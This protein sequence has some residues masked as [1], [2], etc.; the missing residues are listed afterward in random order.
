MAKSPPKKVA[1]LIGVS[2]YEGDL[3]PLPGAPNDVEAMRQ[4]LED[5]ELG[6]FDQVDLLRNPNP[7]E[8]RRAIGRLFRKS[9]RDDLALLFFAGH[10]LLD[11]SDRLYLTTPISNSEEVRE[12]SVPASFL[13]DAMK[14]SRCKRKVVILDCCYSGTFA[15][16]WQAR[17]GGKIDLERQLGGEGQAVLT[18]SSSAQKSFEREGS[19][20]YT[21]YLVEG[22]RG[23]ADQNK[24]GIIS[25]QELH[26]YA[27][28]RVVSATES[29]MKPE[30]YLFK[31]GSKIVLTQRAKNDSE[32]EYRQ[33][34]ERY[35]S[36]GRISDIAREVLKKKQQGFGLTDGQASEIEEQVLVS[37][38]RRIENLERY[39]K[40][41]ATEVERQ[42]PLAE[43]T[44][45]E[46]KDLQ[47]VLELADEDV[48]RI[49][50]PILEQ[51]EAKYQ[52]Q[53]QEEEANRHRQ[54]EAERVKQREE[55][56]KLRQQQE[57]KRRQQ[58]TKKQ[59]SP[60]T[61]PQPTVKTQPF[62]FNTATVSLKS[63]W[64]GL[65]ETKVEINRSRGR[66]EFFAEDLGNGVTLEMVAIPGGKFIMGSPKE[67]KKSKDSERPQHQVTVKPF[68]MGKYQVTQAQWRAVASLPRVNRDLDPN[69]SRFK[70]DSRPVEKV[71]WDNAVEFCARLSKLT[72]RDYRLPS[73]AEWEYACRA[74][75]K[76]PFYFGETI[77]PDLANYNGNYTYG[78]GPKGVYREETT[79]VKQFPPN[80]FGLYDMHGNVWEWCADHWHDNYEGAP[81]D[82]SVWKIGGNE[83]RR[84]LR[85]GSWGDQ[86]RHCR[87]A[88][89]NDGIPDV[90]YINFGFRVVCVPARTP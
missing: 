52:E 76:T 31:D 61:E 57:T 65:G 72:K 62:E 16:N 51:A 25:I 19:G 44:L 58:Q 39:K 29:K 18:S 36:L 78:S 81:T 6:W 82:G 90:R 50:K 2:Q 7:T 33:C 11:E 80:S 46:L 27:K 40:A 89:R 14:S 45:N 86:P 69:P 48:T 4:V 13:H 85:G 26:D 77:T 59:P 1:L 54:Q 64:F 28:E 47:K 30:I 66:A 35:A 10:G 24:D 41:F 32:A 42:Y 88:C 73:E 55:E 21:R 63:G 8:M 83:T 17:S 43:H 56:A 9:Q 37:F 53:L 68:F 12:T 20:I 70:G 67:E 74:K 75:T 60:V 84:V 79:P 23:A 22:L 87:S 5:P 49:E 3:P 71:S 15:E 34:V 38:R